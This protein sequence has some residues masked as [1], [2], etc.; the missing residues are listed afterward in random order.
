M[1]QDNYFDMVAWF[2]SQIQCNELEVNK[3]QS[4]NDGAPP[5]DHKLQ[6][7]SYNI[8]INIYLL[9]NI[10]GLTVAIYKNLQNQ[11]VKDVANEDNTSLSNL[12]TRS[13]SI[14]TLGSKSMKT[15]NFDD[16]FKRATSIEISNF[17]K[18]T[19]GEET[20]TKKLK[21]M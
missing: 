2:I 17:N 21:L 16:P 11:L 14:S 8:N 5:D 6:F 10:F 9:E 20:H 15:K 12:S 3:L 4:T 1:T 13:F 18:E 7:F 19:K